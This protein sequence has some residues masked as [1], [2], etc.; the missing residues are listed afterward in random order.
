MPDSPQRKPRQQS[1]QRADVLLVER[2][3][4]ESRE[5]AQALIMA[6]AVLSPAG[7]VQKAGAFLHPD[8][9]LE[10]KE[11]LPYVSRGGV[12][13]AHALDAWAEPYGISLDGV[14]ALD[15]GA[16]TGGFTDCLLQRGAARV[17]AVDVGHGQLHYRLRQDPRVTCMEKVNVRYPFEL[18]EPVDLLVADVSFIS[19]TMALPEPLTHL[20]AG[21]YAIVL[22]KPQFEARRGEVG[23]GG[24]IRSDA[25]RA[26]I[27]DRFTGWVTSRDDVTLL[28]TI[29]SPITGDAGN[30]EFLALL[31]KR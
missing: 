23:K 19:L 22:V 10:L 18:P 25:L 1:R 7:P 28:D 11:R 20:K 24:I 13:L 26:D 17:Y 2:G 30:R 4:V 6:G 27:L 9:P 3:L 14:T 15:V 16:S 12:K 8:T 21:G 29:P 31:R 5:Q